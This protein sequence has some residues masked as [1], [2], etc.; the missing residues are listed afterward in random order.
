MPGTNIGTAYLQI[1]PS[2]KGIKGNIEKELGGGMTSVGNESGNKFASAFSGA[3]GA[4]KIGATAVAAVGTAT[5]GIGA[6]F[7]KSTGDIAAYGDNID[8]MSQKMG[9]TAEA[10]QEWDAVMQHSGTSMETM[11]ASM[12]TLANAAET[13]SEAFDR[14]GISQE[15]IANMSQQDLFEATIAALQ[16]VGDE[17]ERTYLAGKLLGK[18]ATELGA[19][20]NTSAE[21][22]Q[23]MRDRVRELGGVMSADSVK[24]AAKYQ[25]SLQDM[26]SAMAGMKRGIVSDFLPGVTTAMDGLTE[27]FAG[28][29]EEGKKILGEGIKGIVEAMKTAI[30]TLLEAVKPIA[31]ALGNAFIENF[32]SLVK[33]G[34]NAIGQLILG[35]LQALPNIINAGIEAISGF[36]AGI[37]QGETQIP[38][39]LLDIGTAAVNL[40]KTIEWG[41]LGMAVINLIWN[42]ITTL[43]PIVWEGLKSIASTAWEWFKGV[44]WL[45]LGQTVLQTIWNGIQALSSIVWEGLKEIGST[46]WEWFKDVDWFG[47]GSTV[48]TFIWNGIQS[49]ASTIWE[50]LKEIGSTAWEW[51]KD[52]DWLGLGVTVVTTIV[53]G[54]ASIGST[55]WETIK[56]FADDAV[57]FVT[58]IDWMG[59]GSDII[60]G[61]VNG[62]SA[63]GNSIYNTLIGFA[64]E[65]WEGVKSFFGIGSPSKLM[66]DT[67]GRWLPLG[68]VEGI[69]EE[70]NEVSDA[71]NEMAKTS[72]DDLD[73]TIGVQSGRMIADNMMGGIGG[74]IVINVYPSEGMDERGLAERV[75]DRL[76]LLLQQEEAVWGTA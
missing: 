8:K 34:F 67:V 64:Q 17:T 46:A 30:P 10:Y 4:A 22:T 69:E 6:A 62:I 49:I 48:I 61:I 16:G 36:A 3:L 58:G 23:A 21:E 32:P 12:K 14:L 11:K 51:F 50:A 27:I 47:V 35:I 41:E 43:A 73:A 70:G 39:L 9:L 18:G 25:D 1:M 15:E 65:A 24:A 5:A 76:N 45:G 20:L 72:V 74:G 37:G 38:Q 71:L 29:T 52:V 26:T 28:N 40:F 31:S 33:T 7:V 66:R 19:L 75:S 57:T 42:G 44:D 55:I 2:T 60:N 63:L 59:L 54:L 53:E 56:G 13:N 68:I